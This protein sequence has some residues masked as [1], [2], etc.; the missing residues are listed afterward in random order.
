M[1]ALDY[2][3]LL[4]H[5]RNAHE[6]SID[7]NQ[8]G[9]LRNLGYY[10]GYKGFRFVR[11]PSNRIPFTDV[12]QI[13]ALNKFDLDLK[14]LFYPKLMFIENALKSFLI[15]SFVNDC[16]SGDLNVIYK[17]CLTNYKQFKTG[18]DNYKK[19]FNK[20]MALQMN[21]NKALIRD[22][23]AGREIERHF[24]ENDRQIPV[25]AVF[26]SLSMGEFA[27]FY[28]CANKNV[29]LYVSKIVGL[30][31]NLDSDGELISK[32]TYCLKDL[33]N[34]VA[35]NNTIF[36]TRFAISKISRRIPE[37]LEKETGI[38]NVNFEYISAYILL[39]TYLLWKIKKSQKECKSFINEYKT[40]YIEMRKK[41]RQNIC[42][43]IFGSANALI[44]SGLEKYLGLENNAIRAVDMEGNEYYI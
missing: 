31:T 13:D 33:R 32:I 44:L 36:D 23:T 34:A 11:K 27:N 28:S 5:L 30:P 17:N 16:N 43:G 3:A 2:D 8:T 15:E 26:E 6:I 39:I 4:A 41:F 9:I 19:E 21:V 14:S 18:S 12:N 29:K 40:L 38:K 37:L 1:D 7:Q 20:R 35:H 24:F 25:W 22:Y 42:F 10:H